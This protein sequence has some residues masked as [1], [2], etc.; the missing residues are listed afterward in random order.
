MSKIGLIIAGLFN[1][2][3]GIIFL[4]S[5][6]NSLNTGINYCG[7]YFINSHILECI[8]FP[9]GGLIFLIFGTIFLYMVVN[10]LD[11]K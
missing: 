1:I 10:E 9:W 8:I 6:G 3:L 4:L 5:A 7:Q 2:V 11:V